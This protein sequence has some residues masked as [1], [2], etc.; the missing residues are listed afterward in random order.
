[1]DSTC[2]RDDHCRSASQI[3]GK[4]RRSD[5]DVCN[6][7]HRDCK[8]KPPAT[9]GAPQDRAAPEPEYPVQKLREYEYRRCWLDGSDAARNLVA[10]TRKDWG[11]K[12]AY[13]LL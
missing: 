7:A 11:T 3:E 4:I 9:G 2:T 1:M 5:K 12:P 13:C 10:S 8:G 6:A